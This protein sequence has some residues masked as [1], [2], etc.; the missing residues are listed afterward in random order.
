MIVRLIIACG[1]F[2]SAGDIEVAVLRALLDL[3]KDA[4][5]ARLSF[6]H[7]AVAG[8]ATLGRTP[9]RVV[10]GLSAH[11]NIVPE[12]LRAT[13]TNSAKIV[14]A[15]LGLLDVLVGNG[16]LP[17]P[18]GLIEYD[19]VLDLV[20]GLESIACGALRLLTN[21]A[22]VSSSL[23]YWIIGRLGKLWGLLDKTA[24][25]RIETIFLTTAVI[26]AGTADIAKAF[27][28]NSFEFVRQFV[29]VLET[30][31]PDVCQAALAAIT[32]LFRLPLQL[33]GVEK[34]ARDQFLDA[35]GEVVIATLMES[36]AERVAGL[37][38]A[39]YNLFIHSPPPEVVPFKFI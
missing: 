25:V 5:T 27:V 14:R 4:L 18:V 29:D 10:E 19:W 15:T 26:R 8:L 31:D 28:E 1:N 12:L 36:E 3:L 7:I 6:T 16:G 39:F 35:G 20:D 24:M 34:A 38:A 30:E 33:P 13:G 21:I 17:E 2:P 37:A 9:G 11:G 32:V 23:H 22:G